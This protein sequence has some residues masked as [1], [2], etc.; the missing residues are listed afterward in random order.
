MRRLWI[1]VLA[2]ISTAGV[3]FAHNGMIHVM[4]TVTAITSSSITVKA[5]DGKTATVVLASTTKYER[6]TT[7]IKATDVKVGDRVVIHAVKKDKDLVA[8][9][10]EIGP[11]KGM[12]MKSMQGNMEGMDM[13]GTPKK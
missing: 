11:M 8:A 13:G 4:G 6:G 12:P 9:E 2:L 5:T 1:L 7:T 10:V 3:A